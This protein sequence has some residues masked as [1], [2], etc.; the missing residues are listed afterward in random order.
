VTVTITGVVTV[1]SESYP[2]STTIELPDGARDVIP[3]RP[4]GDGS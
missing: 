4:D 2:V 3:V 1:G